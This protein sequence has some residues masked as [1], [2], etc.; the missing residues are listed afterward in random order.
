MVHYFSRRA[1]DAAQKTFTNNPASV[2][3]YGRSQIVAGGGEQ[4][5]LTDQDTWLAEVS[6]DAGAGDI[7]IY[8]HGY[9]TRRV[10]MFARHRTIERALANEGFACAV[11][12]FDWPSNG[13]IVDYKS[14]RADAKT[15]APFFVRDGVTLLRQIVPAR[16]LHVIAHSM[17]AYLL[18]RALSEQGE[19][20]QLGEVLFVAADVER[21]WMQD[22]AWGGLVMG[23]HCVRL[24]SY[25][26][27]HDEVLNLA[28]FPFLPGGERAGRVGL[29]PKAPP[30]HANISCTARYVKA[31]DDK[32]D[33]VSHRWYF[34]DARFWKDAALTL[35]GTAAAACPTRRA[36]AGGGQE[37][38][39]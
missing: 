20:V 15:V 26:N 21:R 10:D 24:S 17:G 2:T 4:G 12:S 27:A 38:V 22:A 3:R 35:A 29:P 5:N 37:L 19:D 36:V 7:V 11:V 30:N 14:D 33:F 25:C 6:A 1:Y 31:V 8:I 9:N 13:N 32:T 23:H 39:P 34:D 18:L 16:R 28:E